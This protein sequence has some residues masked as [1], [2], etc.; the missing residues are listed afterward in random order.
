MKRSL[1]NRQFGAAAIAAL[2]CA[3]AGHVQ[4]Q[5]QTTGSVSSVVVTAPNAMGSG[6]DPSR[7][8]TTTY[9]V[10]SSDIDKTG[11][12]SVTDVLQRNLP[13]VNVSDTQGNPYTGDVNYRGF[14]ASPL[15][16]T[17]Q[18]LAVYLNG[19]RLNEPFGDTVNWDLVP[20][21]AINGA[22]LVTNNPAFGLNA[23]GGA[24]NL[25][26]KNGFTYR[27]ADATV[28]G[29]S[30]GSYTG[31]AEG[32]WSND[33]M[34]AY[35]AIDGGHEDGW[36]PQSGSDVFR[37]YGDFGFKLPQGEI[38][39]S[40]GA[41]DTK[42]GVVGPSPVDMVE[43]QHDAIFTWPQTT[44]N[45]AQFLALSADTK[46]GGGWSVQG[47]VHWRGF[48]QAHV[49]GNDGDFE[50]C[51]AAVGNFL[52]LEDDAF[53]AAIRPPASQFEILTASGAPIPCPVLVGTAATPTPDTRGCRDR[54][55]ANT[56]LGARIPYG[57]I[58]RTF[59]ESHT[60]GGS[61][62]LANDTDLFG[63]KNSFIVGAAYDKS[64]IHFLSNSTLGLLTPDLEVVTT[65]YPLPNV[66]AAGVPGLGSVIHAGPLAGYGPAE[67]S[68]D[69]ANTGVFASDTF[70]V[71]K[72]L[73]VSL[74][75]R[76]NDQTNN[77]I[78]LTGV[79]PTVTGNHKFTRFNP[80]VNFAW[81]SEFATL[82][83]GYS[84]TNRAPTALELG[85]SDPTKPCLLANSLVSD[86]P[87][88]QVVSHTYEAGMRG[89]HP[90]NSG[91]I[92]WSVSLFSTLNDN[93]II[94][95]PS[96]LVGH[97]SYANV[98]KTRRQ[99]GEAEVRYEAKTW[100]V[101]VNASMVNAQYRFAGDISSP[102]SPTADGNG[103]V[104]VVP[105]DQ[106]SGIP[107]YRVK[108][109]GDIKATSRLTLGVDGQYT[110]DQF[111]V[112]DES[113]ENEKLPSYWTANLRADFAVT[114]KIVLFGRI[115]NLFNNEYVTYGAYFD[116]DGVQEVRPQPLPTDP[117]PISVTPAA[118][119]AYYVGLKVKF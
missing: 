53:P 101:F 79:S 80:A 74:G 106:I 105:G 115:S 84:E 27:G 11:T 4:A 108:L 64:G 15:Q 76:Y 55:P 48:S 51:S 38:H 119:R 59:T 65:N 114:D 56:A 103:N 113:N 95:L 19:Q 93:D 23:L 110:S 26:T 28:E 43:A 69:T 81:R 20:Q 5:D 82:F 24:L 7:S 75:G 16:G 41:S 60:W 40:G 13:G 78:D 89:D 49:D 46:L 8:G 104:T 87:L 112:G 117:N 70:D 1:I 107:R 109:G 73:S 63:H 72:D 61:L 47:D 39:L 86:P 102:N 99:G 58:D 100:D 71:T 44:H 12:L 94:A 54:D 2:T 36:R 18:G 35:L 37:G 14:T 6:I 22:Q 118:P 17:P 91:L 77:I 62:Q 3:L 25:Q 42:V 50:Q 9:V 57:T 66:S 52:C 83:G 45:K 111:V 85:C 88:K 67:V 92:T 68:V 31:G 32:G 10:T 21:E 98:P 33:K 116:S 29:G 96:V 30:F 34:G 97:G 90:W